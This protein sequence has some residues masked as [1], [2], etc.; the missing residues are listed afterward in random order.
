MRGPI[1]EN[2]QKIDKHGL[3]KHTDLGV[4]MAFKRSIME[5]RAGLVG[6]LT[7]RSHALTTY[8]LM[9]GFKNNMDGSIERLIRS[10]T[11]TAW[12]SR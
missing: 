4:E 8:V 12:F 5:D 11:R 9:I 7:P 3:K 10:T 2:S 6:H 1:S